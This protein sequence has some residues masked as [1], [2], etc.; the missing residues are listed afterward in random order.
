MVDSAPLPEKNHD[1]WNDQLNIW[2]N[3]AKDNNKNLMVIDYGA[4]ACKKKHQAM[5]HAFMSPNYCMQRHPCPLNRIGTYF[6]F[7]TSNNPPHWEN[8]YTCVDT[9]QDAN[10]IGT[11][12]FSRAKNCQKKE[13]CNNKMVDSVEVKNN[14]EEVCGRRPPKK[15]PMWCYA[16]PGAKR[17]RWSCTSPKN[18]AILKKMR[19]SRKSKKSRRKSRKKSRKKSRR[20]SRKKSRRK[21]RKKSRR[22]SLRY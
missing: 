6:A 5:L 22:K 20:K 13:M 3:K 11:A 1:R 18:R 16:K 19:K 17:G 7:I 10:L 15:C 8:D 21:S 9:P 4:P 12:K 14:R 2:K